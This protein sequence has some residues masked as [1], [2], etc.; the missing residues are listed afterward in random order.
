MNEKE[1]IRLSFEAA[2]EEQK[3]NNLQILIYAILGTH[4]TKTVTVTAFCTQIITY[5]DTLS[6]K[7]VA[8]S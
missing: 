5:D 2:K 6:S 7:E 4:N 8:Q 1:T 3:M